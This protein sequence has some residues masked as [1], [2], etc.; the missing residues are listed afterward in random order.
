M[1]NMTFLSSW[2]PS[3]PPRFGVSRVNGKHDK[4]GP[5]AESHK[6]NHHSFLR[7]LKVYFLHL[8]MVDVLDLDMG[9]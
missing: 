2:T 6:Q 3:V 7:V 1:Q 4:K 9:I 5:L 8:K